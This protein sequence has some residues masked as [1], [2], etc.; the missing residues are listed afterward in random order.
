MTTRRYYSNAAPSQTLSGSITSGQTNCAVAS[1]SGWPTQFPYFATLEVGTISAEI[2]SVT[3]VVG[4]TATIVRGQDGTSAIAH[5]AGATFDPTFIAKDADEA[6]AHTSSA[7]G[8]TGLHGLA[9]AIVGTTD[10]QTLTNKTLTA[11]TV[12]APVVSGTLAGASETLS[13]T[14]AVSGATTVA[15]L[16]ASGA[17]AANAAGTGLAVA[18]DATVAGALTV[19]GAVQ[20]ASVT[21]NTAMFIAGNTV[22]SVQSGGKTVIESGS[23]TS[24][25]TSAPATAG[26]LTFPTAFATAPIVH[27]QV[28]VGASLDVNVNLQGVTTTTATW[29]LFQNVGTSISATVTVH[30]IAIGT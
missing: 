20:A 25:F 1:F 30:W 29:R 22:A 21:A 10:A 23:F 15:A 2:V 7:F 18:H 9:G 6:N 5:L 3:N 28:I 24:V 12:S 11:P 8:A 17:V 13:G 26:T 16:T 19:T 4:T 27:M 14:L